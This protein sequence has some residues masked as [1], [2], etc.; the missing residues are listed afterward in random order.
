[1]FIHCCCKF[2][3]KVWAI[4]MPQQIG[5]HFVDDIVTYIF[6]YESWS[7]LNQGSQ[8]HS[9]SWWRHQMGKYFASLGLGEGNHRSP[10]DSPDKS[11]WRGALIFSVICAWTNGWAS[12]RDTGDLRR[13]RVHYDANLTLNCNANTSVESIWMVYN[14]W[15]CIWEVCESCACIWEVCKDKDTW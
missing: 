2:T 1:M 11:Q 7:S 8:V 15:V 10:V 14:N 4:L 5:W 9:V 3:A 13:N 6:L 12:N